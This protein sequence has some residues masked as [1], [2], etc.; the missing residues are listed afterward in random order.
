ME[1]GKVNNTQYTLPGL[2][3]ARS[4]R[5]LDQEAL[6]AAQ[7]WVSILLHYYSLA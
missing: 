6:V 1:Q 4:T 5:P 2:V 3:I 7:Q